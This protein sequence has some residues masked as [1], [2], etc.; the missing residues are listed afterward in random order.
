M[1][2]CGGATEH[3]ASGLACHVAST[4]DGGVHGLQDLV[5]VVVGVLQSDPS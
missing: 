4:L 1:L 5:L 3:P 2:P